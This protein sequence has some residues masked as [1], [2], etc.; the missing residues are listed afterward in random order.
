MLYTVF[1][2]AEAQARYLSDRFKVATDAYTNACNEWDEHHHIASKLLR[3]HVRLQYSGGSIA[4]TNAVL[5]KGN[6]HL[7]AM[8]R[9][10]EH[11]KDLLN[12]LHA[13]ENELLQHLDVFRDVAMLKKYYMSVKRSSSVDA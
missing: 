3:E 9:L 8:K 10:S 6:I 2:D 5:E 7:A 13:S 11:K 4:E 12:D 1:M